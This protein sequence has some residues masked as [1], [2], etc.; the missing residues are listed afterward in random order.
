MKTFPVLLNRLLELSDRVQQ[1][2]VEEEGI[3]T[4]NDCGK[5][6]ALLQR[7]GGYALFWYCDSVRT[8]ENP[9]F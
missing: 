5:N 8:Y 4:C 1:F 2:S 3:K 9:Y 6:A 7:C